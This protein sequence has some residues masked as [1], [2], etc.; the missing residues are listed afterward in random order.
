MTFLE[1]IWFSGKV[2][3]AS[4]TTYRWKK[5]GSDT[6]GNDWVWGE[7][8]FTFASKL[9]IIFLFYS[10]LHTSAQEQEMPVF[11]VNRRAGKMAHT[12]SACCTSMGKWVQAPEPMQNQEL[13][14]MHG[15]QVMGRGW[16]QA[17]RLLD[18]STTKSVC[19]KFSQRPVSKNKAGSNRGRNQKLTSVIFICML[20][21]TWTCTHMYIIHIHC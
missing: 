7:W 21:H 20:T 8:V 14:C 19:S 11:K 16:R 6:W 13:C 3:F 12:V 4:S 1:A 9:R 5:A 2:S 10:L 15:I 17:D 18:S